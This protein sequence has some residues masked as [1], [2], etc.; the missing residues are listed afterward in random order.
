M[1]QLFLHHFVLAKLATSSIRVNMPF[2][3]RNIDNEWLIP[4]VVSCPFVSTNG[5]FIVQAL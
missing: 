3:C 5:P 4:E 2:A 1:F